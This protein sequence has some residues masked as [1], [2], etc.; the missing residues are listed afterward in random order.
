MECIA[1]RQYFL[2]RPVSL[3]E[4]MFKKIF[5][6][7]FAVIVFAGCM[8]SPITTTHKNPV[9]RNMIT[10]SLTNIGNTYRIKQIIKTAKKNNKIQIAFI[11]SSAFTEDENSRSAA[12]DTVNQMSNFFGKKVAVSMINFSV[13]GTTS[14]F[15]NIMAQREVL[16]K[17][18]DII[19]L[20]YAM[21]DEHEQSDRENFEALVRSCLEQKNNPQVIIFINAREDSVVKN[22]F[23]EQIAKYYNL[24]VIN[25][26][27]AFLPE[28]TAGRIKP[29]EIYEKPTIHTSAGKEYIAD[30]CTNYIVKAQK[31][32]KDKEY[33]LP[34][35]MNAHLSVQNPKFI[36]AEDIRAE[37]DGS[38]IRVKNKNNKL[39]K[40]RIEYLTNTE[41]IPFIFITEAN[42]VYIIAPVSKN[43]KDVFE[44]LIN[45]KKTKE[46]STFAE[47]END[48]PKVFKVFSSN[49][50]ERVAVAIQVKGDNEENGTVNPY[51][52]S[53][54]P[55]KND[56]DNANTEDTE[57]NE[58]VSEKTEAPE[59]ADSPKEEKTQVRYK[60][61]E[62]WGI[63]F[64]KN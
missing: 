39:F 19:F 56:E 52:E 58:E 45:G 42:N 9:Q 41:N 48:E 51:A 30:F 61:F 43:R 2:S 59:N 63:A 49:V 44:I 46:F 60:D 54:E 10:R 8:P 1:G 34:A 22:D 33:I 62:F 40:S 38:Y 25:V 5:I 4:I 53:S 17:H 20:D 23:M 50:T 36:D 21:F 26:S 28:F 11:G 29:E 32:K 24:P 12:Q 16:S 64:T 37:N 35:P 14:E 7:V 6:I 31:S 15:G 18:P 57:K 55:A 27:S 13:Y 3:G 47:N